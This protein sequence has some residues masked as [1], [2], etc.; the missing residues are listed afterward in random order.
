MV[1]KNK[2]NKH[3]KQKSFFII[4]NLAVMA[5]SL[6]G[7]F[8]AIAIPTYISTISTSNIETR[9]TTSESKETEPEENIEEIEKINLQSY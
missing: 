3:H 5:F 2:L 1:M 7:L 4:R 8:L 6:T 9:A